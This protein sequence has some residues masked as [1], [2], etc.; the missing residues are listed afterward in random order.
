MRTHHL[1]RET[2]N[3][4][5]QRLL[6]LGLPRSADIYDGRLSEALRT[7][8]VMGAVDKAQKNSHS[9]SIPVFCGVDDFALPCMTPEASFESDFSASVILIS[10]PS[11]FSR[12]PLDSFRNSN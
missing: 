12:K 6:S 1:M 7:G 10:Q 11:S 9:S 4:T 5:I 3:S 8:K 2:A